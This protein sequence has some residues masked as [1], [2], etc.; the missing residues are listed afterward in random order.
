MPILKNTEYMAICAGCSDSLTDYQ[1]ATSK[2]NVKPILNKLVF[3]NG[4]FVSKSGEYYCESC[5]DK[6]TK[7]K[8]IAK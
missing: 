1:S 7:T 2:A 8:H 6:L 4:G 3:K 5:F